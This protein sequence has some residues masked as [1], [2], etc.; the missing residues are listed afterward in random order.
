VTAARTLR[1]ALALDPEPASFWNS[2]G[3]ILGAGR[4]MDE[5]ETAFRE[6]VRRDEANAEYVYNLGLALLRQGKGPEAA[7]SF[8]KALQLNP[9]FA[10]ARARLAEIR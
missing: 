9:R 3:M 2:L 4:R 10:P 8:R 6:A 7:A 5:A 1:E